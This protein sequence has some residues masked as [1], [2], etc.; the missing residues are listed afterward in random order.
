MKFF[1]PNGP[2]FPPPVTS[3]A[4]ISHPARDIDAEQTAEATRR[5]N[6]SRA[7]KATLRDHAGVFRL[8]AGLDFV[9]SMHQAAA[10]RSER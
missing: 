3:H 10:T 8:F 6:Q 4:V 7:V 9:P 2:W 5:L 1:W